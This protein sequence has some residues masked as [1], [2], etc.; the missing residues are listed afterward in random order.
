[1]VGMA[2]EVRSRTDYIL[3]TDGHII[4]NVSVRDPMHNLDHYLILGCLRSVT[5]R[6]HENYLWR[7]TRLTLRTPTTL[8][9]EGGLFVSL[10]QMIPKPKD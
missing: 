9:R 4:R 6:E 7:S 1:M 5:L 10:C 8:K 3:D 2:R